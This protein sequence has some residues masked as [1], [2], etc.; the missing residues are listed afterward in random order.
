LQ[1]TLRQLLMRP[2]L[3]IGVQGYPPPDAIP[4]PT[5]IPIMHTIPIRV[6]RSRISKSEVSDFMSYF[7]PPRDFVKKKIVPI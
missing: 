7:Y 3:T 5:I 4:A 6:M 2:L 1:S